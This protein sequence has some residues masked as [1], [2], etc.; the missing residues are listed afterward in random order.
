MQR[1]SVISCCEKS[2]PTLTSSSTVTIRFVDQQES[3]QLYDLLIELGYTPD[4]ESLPDILS[5]LNLSEK[6]YVL[7]A[8]D[9]GKMIGWLH[10][11]IM[12]RVTIG[13]YVEIVGLVVSE[14]TRR[15][16]IGKSLVENAI[17]W[18]ANNH[19]SRIRVRA[20]LHREGAHKFYEGLGFDMKKEQKVFDKIVLPK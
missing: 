14:S 12:Q 10:A 2:T 11:V 17:N 5:K 6:D 9:E 18:T 19:I 16:G 8:Y 20:Q 7:A 15:Q 4:E 13:K 3:D 1:N